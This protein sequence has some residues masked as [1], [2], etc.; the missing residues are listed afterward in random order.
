MTT[1]LDWIGRQPDD[2]PAVLA[3][4][5]AGP[6]GKALGGAHDPVAVAS[7]DPALWLGV[8][9]VGRAVRWSS[10]GL[11]A[12]P[13]D[14]KL[15]ALK[16]S[17]RDP[18]VIW[19]T[20]G[21][22]LAFS[23]R[24]VWAAI[25]DTADLGAFGHGA[26]GPAGFV[27]RAASWLVGVAFGGGPRYDQENAGMYQEGARHFFY[28]PKLLGLWARVDPAGLEAGSASLV[29]GNR[30]KSAR[31]F[32]GYWTPGGI[33]PAEFPEGWYRWREDPNSMNKG[34]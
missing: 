21:G 6:A 30:M 26:Y 10:T 24:A 15:Q 27:Q 1:L 8:W 33:H 28:D 29:Q 3:F 13:G 2:H 34:V 23:H 18:A 7:W 16:P 11:R 20:P 9:A 5:G 14:I 12:W 32:D 17:V 25:Q 31:L 19:P 4:L 22:D